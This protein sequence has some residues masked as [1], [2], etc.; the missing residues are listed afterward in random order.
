[1][2][3][4]RLNLRD[5]YESLDSS[6]K[7]KPTT[8]DFVCECPEC[9]EEDKY[10]LK[11]YIKRD[12][13][14]GYCFICKTTFYNKEDVVDELERTTKLK[15]FK[16]FRSN[17]I[18]YPE[19]DTTY[20]SESNPIDEVT[21]KYLINRNPYLNYEKFK[22]RCRYNRVVIPF[23]YGDALVYYQ[24]RFINPVGP[25]YF[26]PVTEHKPIYMVPGQEIT[27][28]AILSEGTFDV[29]AL[30][31]MYGKEYTKIG[32]LGKTI[33]ASQ[34]K[35]LQKYN[36]ERYIIYLDETELSQKLAEKVSSEF[37]DAKISIVKAELDPE[38]YLRT[39]K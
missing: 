27:D 33:T 1:M 38:E 12:F 9:E 14:V 28:T 32:L 24:I 29:M 3:I 37:P 8:K 17:L 18:D 20:Y 16:P 39:F 5:Y 23:Y 19:I 36:F 31:S 26:N 11:L 34:L 25:K 10:K 30:D 2:A 15:P 13:T 22:L 4:T 7:G 6:Q 35:L 21:E